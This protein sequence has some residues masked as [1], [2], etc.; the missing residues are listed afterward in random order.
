MT[1]TAPNP[2]KL[3]EVYTNMEAAM[4][5]AALE[6]H[7]IESHLTGE[8]TSEFRAEVPGHV[9]ILVND[10]DLARAQQVLSNFGNQ[11]DAETTEDD[12]SG[13]TF[14]SFCRKT[15]IVGLVVMAVMY[16]GDLLIWL[17]K[18]L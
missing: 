8:Y 16:L 15:V 9:E 11:G 3:T 4:I 7:G 6:T 14:R 2:T 17:S 10:A 18:L 5:V 12:H 1:T 13:L